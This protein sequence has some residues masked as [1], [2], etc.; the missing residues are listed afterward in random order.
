MQVFSHSN[1]S[2]R[3]Q[4]SVFTD[5]S[6]LQFLPAFTL[7]NETYFKS[8]LSIFFLRKLTELH[9]NKGVGKF[10]FKIWPDTTCSLKNNVELDAEGQVTFYDELI[11]FCKSSNIIGRFIQPHPYAI[12]KSVPAKSKYCHFG[13][14]IVDLQNQTEEEILNRFKKNYITEIKQTE[15]RGA[16]CKFGFEYL[17]DFYAC[18]KNTMLKAGKSVDDIEYFKNI[19]KYFGDENITV[20]EVYENENPIGSL[21][22]I[23]T[24]YTALYTHAG[25]LGETKLSGRMKYLIWECIKRLKKNGVK[26]LTL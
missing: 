3:K 2:H 7:F 25:T 14:Y 10:H 19:Y 17:S 8:S 23:H 6:P 24:K 1:A 11:S 13:T 16:V 21:F 4:L 20:G 9:A 22:V 12:L 26:N 15:S 5:E 18:Y